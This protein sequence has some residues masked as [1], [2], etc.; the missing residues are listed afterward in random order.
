MSAGTFGFKGFKDRALEIPAGVTSALAVAVSPLGR[1][2][3]RYNDVA[4]QLEQSID[5][6]VYTPLGGTGAG[7]WD[8]VGTDVFPDSTGWD[9]IIGAA[10]VVGSEKLRVVGGDARLEAGLTV[11][12]GSIDLDPTGGFNLDM[13][14]G[15][16]ALIEIGDNF[17]KSFAIQVGTSEY[18]RMDTW[19]GTEVIQFG[20][21]IFGPTIRMYSREVE[22]NSHIDFDQLSSDPA[23]ESDRGQLYC[24]AG[25]TTNTELFYRNDVGGI[26][27][28]TGVGGSPWTSSSGVI[29][30]TTLTDDVAIGATSMVGA[31][32]LRVAGAARIEGKLT[33]TGLIDP[34][35]LVLDEQSTVPGGAPGT[36]KGTFWVKDDSPNKPYFTDDA[37]TDHDLLAGGGTS[38]WT[39]SAGTIYPTT[40]TDDVVIGGTAMS[41][42]ERLRVVGDALVDNNVL[43]GNVGGIRYVQIP[44]QPLGSG[45]NDLYIEASEG[46]DELSSAVGSGGEAQ[47]RGARGGA[48]VTI[49]GG[50]G[51]DANVYGGDGGT[52]SPTSGSGGAVEIRGGT[53]DGATGG[54][55]INVEGGTS[56]NAAG[57]DIT[58][59]GGQG[60]TQNGRITIGTA[61]TRDLFLGAMS[62]TS[63]P[64][65]TTVNYGLKIRDTT[66]LL[67][68]FEMADGRN[69]VVAPAGTGRLRYNGSTNVIEYSENGVAWAQA[70]GGAGSSPWTLASGV[71][72]PTTITDD[73]AVGATTMSG[74]ERFR[75]NGDVSFNGDVLFEA[76]GDIITPQGTGVTGFSIDILPG[77]GQDTAFSAARAGGFLTGIAG[78]GGDVVSGG[79]DGG[80]AGDTTIRGGNGGKGRGGASF[81]GGDGGALTLE[82]GVGGGNTAAGDDVN[83]GP[84]G[85]VTI[86]AGQGGPTSDGNGGDGGSVSISGGNGV[87]T[88]GTGNA[89]QA[90]TVSVKGGQGNI[91]AG[92]GA[93]SPGGAVTIEGGD[94]PIT[95]TTDGG[96]V[97]VNGGDAQGSGND[98]DVNVGTSHTTQVLLGAPTALGAVP[99]SWN[100][101]TE[102]LFFSNTTAPTGNPVAGAYMYGEAGAVKARGSSGTIT[103]VAAA[104]PHCPKCGRD[105][106]VEWKNEDQGWEL[107]VCMWCVTDALGNAGVITKT[108]N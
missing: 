101:L 98:G 23:A 82:G 88:T 68:Y 4:K 89:G 15:Q 59:I 81:T 33:V 56:L 85:D 49:P 10:T 7:P 17:G 70:F 39:L 35:G 45:G 107:A 55:N 12:G 19:D 1:A 86:A 103:T 47:L 62:N 76:S 69:A 65:E 27:Q 43:L 67:T 42:T 102:G 63:S 78:A 20:N 8:Q 50:R 44:K 48:G 80:D 26:T 5:G 74:A 77:K 37:G 40:V 94:A 75:V 16:R 18:L 100:G 28:L 52:G 83:G 90:G 71:I 29:Y 38:P 66:N 46:G 93:D 24:K 13:D 58:I 2:R 84:G 79:G 61:Q 30:P 51:G 99:S 57:G 41:S 32:R 36:A 54:G 73:V 64:C 95:T 91:A 104:D 14:T 21:E 92:T 105:C 97:T 108:E 106:A 53:G 72:Y 96:D 87:N 25:T 34:I 60:S 6:G 31:E 9:V 22:I 3:L 11:T